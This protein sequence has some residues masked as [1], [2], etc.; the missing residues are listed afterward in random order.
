[1][2]CFCR[3]CKMVAISS[4]SNMFAKKLFLSAAAGAKSAASLPLFKFAILIG[5]E[6]GSKF[7]CGARANL[8]PPSAVGTLPLGLTR[9]ISNLGLH[10]VVYNKTIDSHNLL[11]PIA[12]GSQHRHCR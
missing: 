1:M 10:K 2:A 7:R 8:R 12:F 4:D 9:L 6:G 11:L 5:R 3:E